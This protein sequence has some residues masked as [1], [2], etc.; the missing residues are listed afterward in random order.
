MK[1]RTGIVETAIDFEQD[2]SIKVKLGTDEEPQSVIMLSPHSNRDSGFFSPPTKGSYVV[3][4]EVENGDTG[5]DSSSKGF[6]CLG[7]MVGLS[8][9]GKSQDEKKL[10]RDFSESPEKAEQGENLEDE[11]Y[12]VD[13]TSLG[14]KNKRTLPIPR[15][16]LKSYDGK[17]IVAEKQV[18]EDPGGN[19]VVLSHQTGYGKDEGFQDISLELKTGSGKFLQFQDSPANNVIQM[20]SD[21]QQKNYLT[22]AGAQT[23]P[24]ADKHS[25]QNGEFRLDT[26]GPV[27]LMSR[28]RSMEFAVK[29]GYNIDILNESTCREERK[30]K[31]GGSNPVYSAVNA[32][33]AHP[34]SGTPENAGDATDLGGTEAGCINLTSKHNNITI[35]AEAPDS[36]VYI[37]TPGDNSKVTIISGGSVDIIAAG[38][39]TLGS[40]E[41]VAINAPIVDIN[42]SP[43]GVY[44]N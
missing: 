8:P 35:N 25:F 7:T 21:K 9:E 23:G 14:E 29:E 17:K 26:L 41:I 18:W 31:R 13:E 43:K 10:N 15:E 22:F 4:L 37:N 42:G 24:R 3:V 44:I 5:G 12:T 19:A 1:V 2:C 38:P 27:N 32:I 28:G 34:G 39:L 40:E 30:T 6:Y 16:A 36:V 11:P 20:C 33:S